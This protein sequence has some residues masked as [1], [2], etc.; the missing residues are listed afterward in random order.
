MPEQRD[1]DGERQHLHPLRGED[2]GPFVVTDRA[3]GKNHL[4]QDDQGEEGHQAG[5]HALAEPVAKAIVR[6]DDD[7]LGA[8]VH[9]HG[10]GSL[11]L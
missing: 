8:V 3:L 1:D 7:A 2:A 4:R 6:A 5:R 9:G 10:A 11:F